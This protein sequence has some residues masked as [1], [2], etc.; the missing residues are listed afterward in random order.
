MSSAEPLHQS[1]IK[2]GATSRFSPFP[3]D[4]GEARTLTPGQFLAILP[5]LIAMPL[6][7]W[8]RVLENDTQPWVVVGAT[9]AALL[10]FKPRRD[11]SS[12]A[13][14]AVSLL[15]LGAIVA[16]A[17]RDPQFAFLLRY[18][19]ILLTFIL[20]W[21]LASRDPGPI[22]GKVVRL[23]IGI[24]F[25]IGVYQ[26]LAVR[27]GLPVEF[28]GR[29]Q[30]GRSGVPSLTAEPSF[31]GSISVLL[32]M[33]LLTEKSPRNRPYIVIAVLN[34]LLSGSLLSFLLLGIP[35]FRMPLGYKIAG[36]ILGVAA[37]FTG[38]NV[39]QSGFFERVATLQLSGLGLDL[40]TRDASINLR[41]GHIL[42]TMI[43]NLPRELLFL[44]DI[45]FFL[46]YNSWAMF[47]GVYIASNSDFILPTGGELLF[48]SG[49][50]GLFLIAFVLWTS[51]RNSGT[52]YER[53]EKTL[54]V[55]VCF[56]NPIS[57]MNPFFVFYIHKRYA[58]R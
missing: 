43:E 17:L 55:A 1:P 34:V 14:A 35:L 21:H 30:P 53:W 38:I 9:I 51:W 16:Y 50:M 11:R 12:D 28:F 24:W 5:L 29:Y 2:E 15:A 49:A 18:A 44:N 46:E 33:Y 4:A 22:I 41:F 36:G 26:V 3:S 48:R 45:D 42:F 37:L 39:L 58:Q 27:T 54:F 47:T 31:Y 19:G 10:F 56:L 20:L 13:L 25:V 40:L 7:Y 6:L 57:L 8:P 32:L 52:H 23:T